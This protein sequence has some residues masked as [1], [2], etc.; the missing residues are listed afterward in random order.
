MELTMARVFNEN[1]LLDNLGGDVGFLAET[2]QMLETDG[3]TLMKQLQDALSAGDAAAV[4]KTAHTIKGMVSNFCSPVTQAAALEVEKM[5]KSGDL[6]NTPAA[7]TVLA[8]RVNALLLE[9]RTFVK[10]KQ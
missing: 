2:V 8:D 3:P 10:E 4:G 9:L 7:I 1:E 6:S 5:G